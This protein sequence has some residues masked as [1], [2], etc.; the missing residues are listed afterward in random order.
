MRLLIYVWAGPA[1][2]LGLAL[3]LL[4]PPGGGRWRVV[5]GAVEAE[6]PALRWLLRR[7]TPLPGGV[8]AM[9]LGHVVLG[10]D[11]T[12]LARCRRHERVHVRQYQ[13]WG[14]LFLPAYLASSVVQWLA[15]RD[16][17]RD[18]RF[19]REAFEEAPL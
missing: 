1:S 13:R 6:G 2:L 8:E 7:A 11:E 17:Y 4:A 16:P 15:G 3:A 19:E 10:R 18:N 12:A 5:R 14:P 9:T